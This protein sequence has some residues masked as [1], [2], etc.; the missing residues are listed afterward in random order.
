MNASLWAWAARGGYLRPHVTHNVMRHY[1]GGIHIYTPSTDETAKEKFAHAS[2][3]M[4]KV[5]ATYMPYFRR[6]MGQQ[7][8]R[9]SLLVF[10]G[11]AFWVWG[12]GK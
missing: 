11:S 8:K 6:T 3:S 12:G 1:K 7:Y 4:V 2:S 5:I 10:V 9:K